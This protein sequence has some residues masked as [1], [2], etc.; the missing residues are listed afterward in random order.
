MKTRLFSLVVVVAMGLSIPAVAT[1]L[2]L[3]SNLVSPGSSRPWINIADCEDEQS[4]S[5]LELRAS[6]SKPATIQNWVGTLDADVFIS[7]NENCS[8]VSYEIGKAKE[9]GPDFTVDESKLNTEIKFPELDVDTYTLL[10]LIDDSGLDC[11]S[12]IENDYYL[13]IAFDYTYTN[14]TGNEITDRYYGGAAIRIDTKSPGIPDLLSVEEGEKNLKLTWDAPEDDDLGGFYIY[15]KP[16]GAPEDEWQY[17]TVAG[18][19][20]RS[21]QLEGLENFK[22]YD[23]SISAYDLA[24]NEGGKSEIKTGTPTPIE[25][26]YE[27]YRGHSGGSE[28]GGFC[29]VATA[30]YG[31]YDNAMVLELR[32]LRDNFLLNSA[33]GRAFV[34]SYYRLGPRW[35]RA[36]R[37]HDATRAVARWSLLPLAGIWRLH[38]LG[39][40][41]WF[42]LFFAMVLLVW[43]GVHFKRWLGAVVRR[44]GPLAMVVLMGVSFTM[45]SKKASAQELD[46]PKDMIEAQPQ[47]ELQLRLGSYLPSIDSEQG[48]QGT[49]FSDIFGNSS[50]LLFELALDREI[51]RGFGVVTAGA[52]FGFVQYLGKGRTQAGTVASDSTVLNLL[53]LRLNVGYHFTLLDELWDVPLVPY[54]VGGLS[55]YVWWVTDGVG[56]VASWKTEDG[57]TNDAYGGIFGL[58]V[59]L[60]IKLLLD[61]MDKGAAASIQNDV[62][63]LNTFLFAE[64]NYSWVDGFGSG[65]HLSLSDDT[66]MFGLMFEF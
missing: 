45:A 50:E 7:Q 31:S 43:L 49:P 36:I 35:A 25:D 54:V 33:A 12:E 66:V 40:G 10:D 24:D 23:I 61:W 19:S 41:E 16:K 9:I 26:F 3:E 52:S 20:V 55:Y 27:W 42:V 60:G 46:L 1:D 48:L 2:E 62:G 15:Y 47:Y 32:D 8:S 34:S 28:S 56:D 53:P 59:G 39:F 30:A 17:K 13:C 65:N 37:G 44:A 5:S 22:A 18:D 4:Q 57:E 14:Y 6:W 11:S 29:F 21:Y 64:Y 63:V 51:W 38:G 58:H